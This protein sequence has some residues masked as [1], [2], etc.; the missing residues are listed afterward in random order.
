MPMQTD[1]QAEKRGDV[2]VHWLGAAGVAI[3]SGGRCVLI[4]PYFSRLPLPRLLAGTPLPDPARIAAAWQRLPGAVS[5]VA[6]SH[7]HIDHALDLPALARLTDAPIF[8]NASLAA[9]LTRAALP[10]RVD[11]CHPGDARTLPPLGRLTVFAGAHGGL[12]FG[13]PPL[14]GEIAP[15]GPQ[16]LRARGYRAGEVLVFDLTI[17]GRRFVHVGSAGVAAD[18][19]PEGAC[20]VLFL[21][22]PGW[23]T[24]PDYPAAFLRR[25]RP[26]RI[27]PIHFDRMTRPL[28]DPRTRQPDPLIMRLLDLPGFL[29]RLHSAAPDIP[30][31][32]PPL[33]DPMP[34]A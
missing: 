9:L 1:G 7:T 14:P 6:V 16:P 25:L 33:W 29:E 20:D 18:A 26:Q 28:D 19:L 27:V 17:T 8:G 22:V 2:T 5:A 34:P 24:Q 30:V 31:L 11:V 23:R 15:D 3:A 12:L 10:R 21:C 32:W 4:D 13:R